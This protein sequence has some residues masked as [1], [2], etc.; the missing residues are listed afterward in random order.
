[1]RSTL[2]SAFR[3]SVGLTLL[4]LVALAISGCAARIDAVRVT[5]VAAGAPVPIEADIKPFLTTVLTPT[6]ETATVATPPAFQPDANLASAGPGLYTGNLAPKTYG[7]H[8]VRV[9]APYRLPLVPGTQATSRERDFLIGAPAACFAF[10]NTANGLEGWTLAGIF[11]GDNQNTQVA[12]CP[13]FS[14]ALLRLSA[15]NWPVPATGLGGLAV[16]IGPGCYPTSTSAVTS[17]FWSFDFVSPSVQNRAGWAN[18][19][20]FN[21]RINSPD[22]LIVPDG[23]KVQALLKVRKPDGTDSFFA[24]LNADGTLRFDTVISGYAVKS[25]QFSPPPGSVPLEVRIRIFGRPAVRTADDFVNID[26][27]CPG[28]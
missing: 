8:R 4:V 9:T 5:S 26:G 20:A 24:Q 22:S 15:A 1:M 27:I 3:T 21:F 11:D 23:L 13:N 16:P 12:T 6:T 14:S 2:A 7:Q 19:T 18:A 28:P 10:D 17:G 25:F